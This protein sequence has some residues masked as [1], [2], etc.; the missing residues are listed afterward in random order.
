MGLRESSILVRTHFGQ[1]SPYVKDRD[2]TSGVEAAFETQR[3]VGNFN[4]H[5]L[6]GSSIRR[7]FQNVISDAYAYHLANTSPW[8]DDGYRIINSIH[9]MDYAEGLRKFSD[10]LLQNGLKSKEQYEKDIQEDL[11]RLGKLAKPTD[12]PSYDDFC[13]RFYIR[14]VFLPFPNTQDF[15]VDIAEEEKQKLEEMIKESSDIVRKDIVN[16]ALTALKPILDNYANPDCKVYDSHRD[17][18]ESITNTITRLNV[19]RDDRISTLSSQLESFYES[20]DVHE[21]RSFPE[22][23]ASVYQRAV[24]LSNQFKDII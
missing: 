11:V 20:F 3:G 2:A 8:H 21:L 5:L 6:K 12:Y 9:A 22:D 18:L 13:A 19:D 23:K 16:K 10:S 24:T 7:E 15:R 14:S 4:K 1:W 17:K